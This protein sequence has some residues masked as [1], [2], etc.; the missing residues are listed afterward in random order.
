MLKQP[1]I[2]SHI[3]EFSTL[4][5]KCAYLHDRKARME[6][7]YI[8]DCS[9]NLNDGLVKRGWRRFGEYFSRPQCDNCKE[10]ISVRI[11]AREFKFSKSV[12]RV[13][14]KN[15]NQTSIILRKPSITK[16]H[17]KLYN[18]YHFHMQKKR[19]WKHYPLNLQSYYEL[20]VNGYG[21]FGLEFLYFCDGKL[22][23][24]DLVDEISDGLSSIYFFYDPDYA[25][26]SLGRYSI[27]QQILYALNSNKRWIYLGYYVKN[28]Q[29]LEYKRSYKPLEILKNNPKENQ[30]PIWSKENLNFN[31]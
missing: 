24:V 23:G 7:K 29:S 30:T 9:Y 6:Y 12:R 26:L 8:K 4:P 18:K 27:Y 15:A 28:C 20:Y 17:V 19:G 10:C 25:H 2:A 31:C 1:C 3:V 11:D 21:S 13:L 14:K 5:S 16:E 22:V